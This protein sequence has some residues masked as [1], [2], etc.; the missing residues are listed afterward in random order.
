VCGW[1]SC[2]D[3]GL[4]RPHSMAAKA[5]LVAAEVAAGLCA[6]CSPHV[7]FVL[8]LLRVT[9]M[10]TTWRKQDCCWDSPCLQTGLRS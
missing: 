7:V 8:Q 3:S 6:S 1:G 5:C 9:S 10:Y 4:I 2:A